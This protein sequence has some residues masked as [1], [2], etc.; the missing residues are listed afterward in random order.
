[1]PWRINATV[2]SVIV[3]EMKGIQKYKVINQ[4]HCT[5]GISYLFVAHIAV[6]IGGIA[7]TSWCTAA[8]HNFWGAL[9]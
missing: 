8:Q 7:N 3:K 6:G 4:A 1:M 5:L 2:R 9:D